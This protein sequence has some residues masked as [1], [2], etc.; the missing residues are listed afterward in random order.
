MPIDCFLG[1]AL[2]ALQGPRNRQTNGRPR[3][4]PPGLRIQNMACPEWQPTQGTL[5]HYGPKTGIDTID[6]VGKTAISMR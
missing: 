3:H 1:Q 2:L 6:T 4:Y 5:S